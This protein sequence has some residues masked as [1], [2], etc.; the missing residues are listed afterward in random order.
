MIGGIEKPKSAKGGADMRRTPIGIQTFD[1]IITDGFAYVDK[2]AWVYRLANESK[3]NFLGRP[4]RFGKS[5][6]VSTLRAYFE[7][8]RELF[9]GLAMEKLEKEW[10][11]H[12]VLHID[13]TVS[14]YRSVSDL[15]AA[16]DANLRRLEKAWR[17][18]GKHPARRCPCVFMTSF[19]RPARK[20]GGVSSCS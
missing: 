17:P 20:P 15:D 19:K 12:P 9:K 11:P 3:Y 2:T 5:L 8:K 7:G 6:F 1:E 18:D 13:L 4:R 14:S 16:L 10:I